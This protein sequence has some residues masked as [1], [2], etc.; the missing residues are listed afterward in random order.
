[1]AKRTATCFGS[2]WPSSG[3][4]KRTG[5]GS[6]YMHCGRTRGVEI[7]IHGFFL[8]TKVKLYAEVCWAGVWFR[9][10]GVL[11]R[12]VVPYWRC[13]GQVCGSVRT[14]TA[15]TADKTLIH[16]H[17]TSRTLPTCD[18]IIDSLTSC[19]LSRRLRVI[20]PAIH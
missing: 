14:S 16:A 13:A 1:M 15:L 8:F 19:A 4:H 2:Y 10:G 7:S 9:T 11:G 18:I 17:T 5:L 12:C 3:C 6:Y 20:N